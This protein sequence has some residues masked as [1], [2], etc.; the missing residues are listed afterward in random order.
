MKKKTETFLLVSLDDDKAKKLAQVISS[1]TAKKLLD[2]LANK[3][4]TETEMANSLNM[5]IATVHYN[6]Q[7]LLSS[8]LVSADEF[9]YSKKG[10][11]VLHY[12][13]AKKYII[14]APKSTEGLSV[15]I[16]EI[17]P[18]AALALVGAAVVQ[19]AFNLFTVDKF[20]LTAATAESA[21]AASA[22]F[23]QRAVAQS[24][25]EPTNIIPLVGILF[26]S[27]AIFAILIWQ[28]YRAIRP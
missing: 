24:I 28:L 22:D 6:L 5:P 23:T 16:K 18:V 13:L 15:K 14:I 12:S 7:Q 8:G 4:M 10:R 26:F 19:F 11:E 3:T 20:Q 9:H 17:L 27:G 21:G 25:P 2:A 1:G